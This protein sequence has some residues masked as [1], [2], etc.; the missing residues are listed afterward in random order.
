M[1]IK[2]NEL[3]GTTV[4]RADHVRAAPEQ[5]GVI[6]GRIA[7]ISPATA[8]ARLTPLAFDAANQKWVVWSAG[9]ELAVQEVQTYTLGAPTGGTYKLSFDGQQTATIAFN[10]NAAAVSSALD[11]L[12]N[13]VVTTDYVV[14]G[15]P[16]NS[17]AIVVTFQA[18]G[19]YGGKD[20][21][22]LQI[23]P[24][25]LTGSTGV[26]PT[27]ATTTTQGAAAS[28][29]S[30]IGAFLWVDGFV[31]D[32]TQDLLAEIMIAGTLDARDV[33]LPTGESQSDLNEALAT[34]VRTKDFVVFG[35]TGFH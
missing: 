3:F 30:T 19:A 31:S 7:A 17:A 20:V 16:S 33:P 35:I 9:A 26:N 23:D 21:P 2:A 22:A 5:D 34:Q 27:V 4:Q 6:S 18:G 11:A 15:G 29:L 28:G 24:S 25:A 32:A 12:S 14:S 10:A 8:L 13:L 1:S